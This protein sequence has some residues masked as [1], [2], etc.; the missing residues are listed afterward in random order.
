MADNIISP[1][2]LISSSVMDSG[3]DSLKAVGVDKNQKPITPF[4][5]HLVTT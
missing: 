1:A 4:S 5:K 2:S 3:G